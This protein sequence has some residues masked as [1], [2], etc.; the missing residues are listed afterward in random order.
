MGETFNKIKKPSEFKAITCILPIWIPYMVNLGDIFY[1]DDTVH[2]ISI[3]SMRC[4]Y[5]MTFL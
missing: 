1:K 5:D 2:N 4:N 3:T